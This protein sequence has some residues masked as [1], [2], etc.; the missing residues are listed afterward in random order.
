MYCAVFQGAA[1]LLGPYPYPPSSPSS[2]YCQHSSTPIQFNL[3]SLPIQSLSSHHSRSRPS[4]GVQHPGPRPGSLR[5]MQSIAGVASVLAHAS[6]PDRSAHPGAELDPR[7]GR[8]PWFKPA[9]EAGDFLQVPLRP[10][11][12]VKT[13]DPQRPL[14][15]SPLERHIQNRQDRLTGVAVTLPVGIAF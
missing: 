4:E 6:G 11:V 15:L 8:F 9:H 10:W 2:A 1:V 13:V 14:I 12:G 7:S 5:W 3:N